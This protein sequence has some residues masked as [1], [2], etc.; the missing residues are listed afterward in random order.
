MD[1]IKIVAFAGGVG[2]AKLADGLAQ[3]LQP[4]CITVVVNTGDDFS[5]LGLYISPDI[6]T[7]CYTLAGIANP[8]TG[9]GRIND[10]FYVIGELKKMG[11]PGWFKLGDAD[12]AIQLIRN[13]YLKAGLSRSQITEII[14]KKLGV[15]VK[16]LPMSDDSIQTWVYTTEGDLE[17]QEYF[18]HRCC[19]PAV[20]GFRFEGAEKSSP[21]PGVLEAIS[22]SDA[23]ILCPSNP[24][25][26]I[27]PILAVPKIRSA[28]Q[29]RKVYAVSP[30]IGTE[31]VKGPAAKMFQEM[32]L[33]ASALAVAEHYK[34]TIY[35]L[36]IDKIDRNLMSDI[37]TIGIHTAV[38]D[39][40]MRDR[41]DRKRLAQE[42]IDVIS[43]DVKG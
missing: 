2:G 29:T 21:A 30:I 14:C 7:V 17:F 28:I 39:I 33:K 16:V 11:M 12:L 35:C 9:W 36:V 10:T 26:S 43:E 25:V 5:H 20:K 4:N 13:I 15:K 34:G 32:G 41:A 31:T 6:D 37:N 22:Q 18:V 24:W 23:V 40:L 8:E 19:E 42:L 3:V 38:T 1:D 27:D